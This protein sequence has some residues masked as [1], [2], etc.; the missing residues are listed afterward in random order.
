MSRLSRLAFVLLLLFVASGFAGLIYQ[1]VW[2]HYLGL[3]LGHAA[4]A[5]TLVL[6][7]F[8]GGMAIGAWLASRYS[9]HWRRLILGYAA[10]EGLIGLFGLIFHPAFVA[11][12]G[13]SQE[14]VLPALSNPSVA[15]A[16]QWL[17]AALLIVPQS[18]LLGAT[19]PLMSA[20]LM[21]AL[22][23][24]NGEVLGGL[25]FTNSLGA[26]VG[27][28]VATFVLIP[29][30]GLP[31][32]VMAA[33]L[34]N[35][36]V[37]IGAWALSKLL[38][39][40]ASAP[41]APIEAPPSQEPASNESLRRL[42]RTLMISTAISGAAS[43]VYEIGWVR[44]LNQALGTTVHNFELM[45][46]A[47]ILGLAFGGL[48]IRKRA[49]NIDEPVRYV[50]YVQML[51]GIAALISVPVFTQSFEWVQWM[52][53]ALARTDAGYTLFELG[54]AAIAVLVMFPAA[55]LAGM[56]L[57]LFTMAL[58]KAGAGER[59][60]GRIYA[61]NTLGAIVG[62][63]LVTHALIPL[64]GVPL[65]V[66]L[67]AV[68]DALL[69]IYLL[70]SVAKPGKRFAFPAAAT[71][72]AAALALS[73]LLGKPDPLAQAS[74]VYRTGVMHMPGAEV[75][76]LRDG[77][78]STVSVIDVGALRAISTNG[79]PDAALT[80]IQQRPTPDEATMVLAG[81]VPLALHPRPEKVAIIGWGSGLSTHTVLGSAVPKTVVTIEIE[82]AM[83]EAARLFGQRVERAYSDPRSQ[84]RIDDAR[85]F[86]STGGRKY[87]V[88]ISEPSNPW[89]S[90]VANLFTQEFYAFLRRHL[91][92]GGMLV[93]WLHTY[94][95]SDPLVAT[96][97]SA[98]L[99][100]FPNTEVYVTGSTD[101]L[102]VARER[103]ASRVEAPAWRPSGALA[104]ELERVGLSREDDLRIRRIGGRAVLETFVRE[105]SAQ[106]HSDY[107][108][109]V[110]LQAPKS[111]FL[112][113]QSMSLQN[114]VTN[115]MPVLDVLECRRPFGGAAQ[116]SESDTAS[117]ALWRKVAL[118]IA[119]GLK[120]GRL[121]LN[122]ALPSEGRMQL[123]TL[124]A[125]S[126]ALAAGSGDAML[127]MEAAASTARSTIGLLPREDLDGVWISPAWMPQQASGLDAI[128]K[129]MAAYSAASHRAPQQM[130]ETALRV[131]E[132]PKE[133]VPAALRE[134]MLVIAMLGALGEGDPAA[135]YQLEAGHGRSIVAGDLAGIRRYLAAWSVGPTRACMSGSMAPVAGEDG[136]EHRR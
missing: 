120:S 56:T 91:N 122:T 49:A 29:A 43:F 114:L 94:E 111:R 44:L 70:R 71:A 72:T 103:S 81:M 6:A 89:V 88:I 98:L 95:L 57:P 127:W 51:M 102:I 79:K 42:G 115:G 40:T 45:L 136:I 33:G 134:Q 121:P 7:I 3:T 99:H 26:A 12:T 16:W 73:L 23:R 30:V 129:I 9:P 112:S 2:S 37:A 25:Y 75:K 96:M 100:E 86:F 60:I 119:G 24:Q 82:R 55:F 83:Y 59:V 34:V 11:Y 63:A 69:G 31:G 39:E 50:G 104:A 90:G 48:W 28:L 22:P 5:Q 116:I 105:F 15:H 17:S 36:I 131:L 123:Q 62:V 133:S 135:V 101:L 32:T 125:Q 18:V 109:T 10:V 1:S 93:Q 14:T 76:Y 74:G 117:F 58:L 20:G 53:R 4:Y 64:L 47:F 132:L 124:L 52:M 27:A 35:I 97:L 68:V 46:A 67:A 118:D 113:E 85:T 110:S 66:T 13:F 8:M 41:I 106:P 38:D 84:V 128:A 108:P 80:Q 54:T 126:Q 65:S 19:F 87:D 61:A 21:R 77:Q 107:F 78:T 92:Q 130:R